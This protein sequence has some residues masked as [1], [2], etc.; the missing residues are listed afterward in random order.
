MNKEEL[1]QKIARA[2]QEY[3]ENKTTTLKSNKDVEYLMYESRFIIKDG[4]HYPLTRYDIDELEVV[5]NTPDN[6][7]LTK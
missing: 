2:K 3:K 5:G 1:K 6:K 7:N 4:M